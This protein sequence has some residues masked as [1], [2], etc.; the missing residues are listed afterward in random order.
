LPEELAERVEAELKRAEKEAKAR[1]REASLEGAV[2]TGAIRCTP[3][4]K[5]D[6]GE[7]LRICSEVAPLKKRLTAKL[8]DLLAAKTRTT[9][10][11]RKGR[12]DPTRIHRFALG[13]EDIYYRRRSKGSESVGF[14][15]LVDES[16]S[17]GTCDRYLH[18]R[19][20]AVLFSEVLRELRISH[21]VLG[22]TADETGDCSTDH[23]VYRTFSEKPSRQSP[24]IAGISARIN[25]RDGTSIRVATEYL[26]R[27]RFRKKVLLVVS[28]GEP[29]ARYYSP[30][31]SVRDTA[32]AV[33]E[34]RLRGVKTI[35]IS[36]D[37]G[38]GNYL[39]DIYPSRVVVKRLEELPK[40]LLKVARREL[41]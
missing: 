22:F 16:G 21:M 2:E 25:N 11:L 28:D 10:G 31:G 33:R 6:R 3:V 29:Y 1:R 15:L 19:R 23:R 30:P 14:L 24:S 27:Q 32:R 4:E 18:A 13:R 5:G 26:A 38:A 41:S 20:A 9:R 37:P 40:K 35:G 7:Y 12:L 8:K 17:M 39:G 36:I 34:A